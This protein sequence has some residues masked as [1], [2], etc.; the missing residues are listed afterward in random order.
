M[1]HPDN[2]PKPPQWN[3]DSIRGVKLMLNKVISQQTT[4]S[5]EETKST[6]MTENTEKT[7]K[8]QRTPKK[9]KKKRR[10]SWHTLTMFIG[11]AT[12]LGSAGWWVYDKFFA[13]SKDNNGETL[14]T[15]TEDYERVMDDD[16][17]EELIEKLN[18]PESDDDV[19]PFFGTY[20]YKTDD[21]G[22]FDMI[23]EHPD[24]D[25]NRVLARYKAL[26][27]GELEAEGI[28]CY[29]GNSIFGCFKDEKQIGKK[30][31]TYFYAKKE[32]KRICITNGKKAEDLVY[33]E[34]EEEDDDDEDDDE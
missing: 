9:K 12:M 7:Q 2:L 16:E 4:Q 5:G 20:S 19:S 24:G 23:F 17:L 15:Y 10:F 6:Q 3:V 1:I 27:D 11:L 31:L 33:Q 13:N 32:G 26:I 25:D 22:G 28:V 34:E 21:G 18:L 14:L 29:L 30:P 8:V